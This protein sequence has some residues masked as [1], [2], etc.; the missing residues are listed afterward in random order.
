MKY[1]LLLVLALLSGC[2]E[3][4]KVGEV[5][6]TITLSERPGVN[7]EIRYYEVCIS[8]VTYFAS[9]AHSTYVIGGA[10]VDKNGK[11]IACTPK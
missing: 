1:V 7:H 2:K 4:V 3:E 6:T 5:R 11:P 9:L 8:N 10:K